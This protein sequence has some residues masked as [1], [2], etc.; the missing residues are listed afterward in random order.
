MAVKLGVVNVD[1]MLRSL[2]AKQFI[3]WEMY[4]TIEPFSE[5]RADY[6][7]ASIV[8]SIVN[9]NRRK[10]DKPI[11]LEDAMLRFDAPDAP[12]RGKQPWQQKKA[13]AQAIVMAYGKSIE[14]K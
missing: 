1:K 8:M 12:Q 13:I 9:A 6:R 3:E 11:T 7:A 14:K 10:K 5:K 4:A 2:T